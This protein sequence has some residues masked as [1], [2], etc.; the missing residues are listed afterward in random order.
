MVNSTIILLELEKIVWSP[1]WT[2]PTLGILFGR[3]H[4]FCSPI[5]ATLLSLIK[6]RHKCPILTDLFNYSMVHSISVM[7][8]GLVVKIC[9]IL[10]W[11]NID[12]YVQLC[13]FPVMS[14]NIGKK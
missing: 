2:K 12:T 10:L 8:K 13:T 7:S 3:S 4:L 11:S 5:I 1:I 6:H 14:S 9:L